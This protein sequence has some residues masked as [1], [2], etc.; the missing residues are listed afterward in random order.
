MSGVEQDQQLNIPIDWH[1]PET[2]QSRYA[3]NVFVQAGQYEIVVSFFE[4]QI[5]LLIGTPEENRAK[6]EQLGVIQAE[7]VGKIIV[8]PD[9]VPKIIEA[10]QKG[11]EIYHANKRRE[12]G[13]D[14]K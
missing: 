8:N 6:L 13:E 14:I 4:T 10:F 5:P 9:L 3:S 12:E 2:I 11:L 1:V 7:C